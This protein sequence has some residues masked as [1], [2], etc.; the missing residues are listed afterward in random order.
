M[1]HFAIALSFLLI[2]HCYSLVA[3]QTQSLDPP[4]DFTQLVNPQIDTHNS[5][6][7]YFNSACRPF[8]MVNLSPD[9]QTKGSWKSGY[10]Y[11]DKH[12]R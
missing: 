11:G 2:S 3:Q 7:F 10:L 6:W 12:I 9:T 4:E 5:R 8:G 1:K